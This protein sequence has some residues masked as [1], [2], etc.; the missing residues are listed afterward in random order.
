M[1]QHS[2]EERDTLP[3]PP[4]CNCFFPAQVP[5]LGKEWTHAP[6]CPWVAATAADRGRS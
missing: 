4:P 1:A 6:D 5:P 2:T 3:A